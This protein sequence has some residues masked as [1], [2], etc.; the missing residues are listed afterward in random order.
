MYPFENYT[1]LD[2][3]LHAKLNHF[4]GEGF[5]YGISYDLLGELLQ[6][7]TGQSL[8]ALLRNIYSIPWE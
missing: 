4:P 6:I 5:T 2:H 7:I 1:P 8:Q 3:F